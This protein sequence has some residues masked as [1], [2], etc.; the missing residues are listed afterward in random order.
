[1]VR[2]I[3]SAVIVFIGF[4]TAFVIKFGWKTGSIVMAAFTVFILIASGIIGFLL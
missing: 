4:Y 3:I 1:M 2:I